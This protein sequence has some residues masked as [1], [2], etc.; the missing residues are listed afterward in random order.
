MNKKRYFK[1]LCFGV[2]IILLNIIGT[3]V[4]ARDNYA[5]AAGIQHNTDNLI[6]WLDDFDAMDD[7]LDAMR[8]YQNAGYD[9]GG[10]INP[11]KQ[12]FWENLYATVQFFAGHGNTDHI[13]FTSTGI[14][15]GNDRTV[16]FYQDGKLAFENCQMVGT[17]SVHWDADTILVTYS[18]CNT[19]GT[20]GV[21]TAETE[22]IT[23]STVLRGSTAALGFTE[24]IN[25]FTMDDWSARYNQKLG[26]GYTLREAQEYA[27]SFS[28]LGGETSNVVFHRSAPNLRIEKYGNITKNN[29]LEKDLPY[30]SHKNTNNSEIFLMKTLDLTEDK[31]SI[32][33][34]DKS[35]EERNILNRIKTKS[36]T[37]M[38]YSKD[39]VSNIIKNTNSQFDI[40]DYEIDKVTDYYIDVLKKETTYENTYY[41]YNLKIGDFITDAAYTVKVDKNNNVVAIFDNNIDLEKQSELLE[42]ED[43][44]RVKIS[45]PNLKELTSK[46]KETVSQKYDN[47][48][49]HTN[50]NTIYYYD[51]KNDKK[52]V[53]IDCENQM[54]M[55]EKDQDIKP[56]IA[57][58]RVKFEI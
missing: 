40:N 58:D 24:K 44:F 49:E 48:I 54:T 32:N 29:S 17:N 33:N 22:S 45:E 1:L 19:A 8:A 27:N 16:D 25:V 35:M 31:T 2:I 52:Y 43:E 13:N 42:K 46:A 34:T 53:I 10:H 23:R 21:A 47:T 26:E 37:N 12:I 30:L 36:T 5:Y 14:I 50:Q 38:K 57:V 56:S 20:N 18:G 39:N 4:F 51:I 41:N 3:P 6:P 55:E 11:P 9:V 7:C 28:Y 15:E